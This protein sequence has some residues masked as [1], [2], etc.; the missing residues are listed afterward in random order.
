MHA[1]LLITVNRVHFLSGQASGLPVALLGVVTTSNFQVAIFSCMWAS[2]S[3]D[4]ILTF[5]SL[6]DNS[7][8]HIPRVLE[9]SLPSS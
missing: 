4:I 8:R 3:L 2:H 9:A 6:D 5:S 1:K 7:T